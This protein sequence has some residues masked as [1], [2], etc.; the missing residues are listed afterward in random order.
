MA[1]RAQ[2]VMRPSM[3]FAALRH[4]QSSK[5]EYVSICNPLE[6]DKHICIYMLH[7]HTHTYTHIYVHTYISNA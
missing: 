1:V 2:R 7:T 4:A 5:N 3:S 6:T